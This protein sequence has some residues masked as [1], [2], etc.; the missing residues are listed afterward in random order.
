MN[1]QV[2][3]AEELLRLREMWP[4]GRARKAQIEALFP[5]RTW[6]GVTQRARIE[7][8]R[9]SGYARWT[10]S[11]DAILLRIYSHATERELQEQ[12]PRHSM[13]SIQKRANDLG[14]KRDK[15]ARQSE[16]AILRE[17]RRIRRS[18]GLRVDTLAQRFA[19]YGS[20]LSAWETGGK[21]PNL[22][23]FLAW[24]AALE[25]EIVFQRKGLV[26]K[27]AT[28]LIETPGAHRLMAR[29]ASASARRPA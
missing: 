7:G 16:F 20:T 21:V 9:K 10:S 23:G 17:L 25:L 2:W 5:G 12:I 3:G 28:S 13:A 8:L 19:A 29:T 22:R 14:I 1:G 15:A 6:S 4:K 18:R 24:V 27:Q 26:A 11:E